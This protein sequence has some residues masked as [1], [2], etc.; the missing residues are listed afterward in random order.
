MSSTMT[1]WRG[2]APSA[3]DCS[4]YAFIAN[5]LHAPYPGAVQDH[6]RGLAPLVAYDARMAD[7]VSRAG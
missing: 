6:L 7:C 3:L 4:A 1:R 5:A 2:A